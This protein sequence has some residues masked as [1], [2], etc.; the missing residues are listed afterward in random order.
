MVVLVVGADLPA[1]VSDL[2][3]SGLLGSRS[4]LAT[5]TTSA[6]SGPVT[7]DDEFRHVVLSLSLGSACAVHLTTP[8]P[9]SHRNTHL[10]NVH[11]VGVLA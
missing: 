9:D 1:C 7:M 3:F 4:T 2:G 8:T 5:T 6:T 10:G 11:F